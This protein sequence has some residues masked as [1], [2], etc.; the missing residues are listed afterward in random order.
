MADNQNAVDP[1]KL[2]LSKAVDR[3]ADKI[4]SK[5]YRVYDEKGWTGWKEYEAIGTIGYKL[6]VNCVQAI[7]KIRGL[8]QFDNL[9]E[10]DLVDIANLAMFLERFCNEGDNQ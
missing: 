6:E 5:L 4:K 2:E 7:H 3:F 9:T 8:G 10:D 1:E